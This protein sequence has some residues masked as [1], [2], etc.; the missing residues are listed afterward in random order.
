[1]VNGSFWATIV[2]NATTD[3]SSC[4]YSDTLYKRAKWYP[5][6]SKQQSDYDNIKDHLQ[7]SAGS[8]C[9]L[10]YRC[11]ECM[12]NDCTCKCTRTM[13]LMHPIQILSSSSNM[14]D[15]LICIIM[16]MCDKLEIL[17]ELEELRKAH[18]DLGIKKEPKEKVVIHFDEAH[19]DPQF[20]LHK[21]ES[22]ATWG[23]APEQLSPDQRVYLGNWRLWGA[24]G[25]TS[26]THYWEVQ[27]EDGS[28]WFVGVSVNSYKARSWLKSLP[29]SGLW[30]VMLWNVGK[31][32][33][34]SRSLGNAVKLVEMTKVGVLLDFDG[35]QV[36]GVDLFWFCFSKVR[37]AVPLLPPYSMLLLML[38]ATRYLLCCRSR[39][40]RDVP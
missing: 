5:T 21:A 40:K 33:Y 4:Q 20:V 8:S 12:S 37:F 34:P 9:E 32:K 16:F 23:G 17:K 19:S 31:G 11:T 15:N 28:A 36:G 39:N 6:C 22:S 7:F 25:F 38:Q 30:L 29:S 35:G 14:L 13:E 2:T 1:M 18:L 26:G 3:M 24:E 27:V 10:S